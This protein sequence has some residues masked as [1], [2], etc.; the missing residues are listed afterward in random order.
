MSEEELSI[1]VRWKRPSRRAVPLLAGAV[2]LTLGALRISVAGDAGEEPPHVEL[3]SAPR[4][5]TVALRGSPRAEVRVWLD[6]VE[7]TREY[8]RDGGALVGPTHAA[9][10]L[11]AVAC[12]ASRCSTL[13][14]TLQ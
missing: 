3:A 13:R 14:V 7:R 2:A 11:T 8:R 5:D 10:Q 6:G 12:V 9:R 4:G 1:N